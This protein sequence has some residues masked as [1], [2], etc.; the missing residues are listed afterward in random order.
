MFLDERKKRILQ[1][2][3]NDYVKFAEPIASKII[4][5]KYDLDLSSATIRNEMAELEELGLI[6]KT[7]TSSG[8]VPSDL[9]YRYYV[10][11]LMDYYDV[12]NEELTNL[13]EYLE[14]CGKMLTD[15]SKMLSGLTHYTTISM[16]KN[17]MVLYGR[18]NVFDYPEF[19]DI[20]RLKKFM[21]LMEEEERIR[22]IVDSYKNT[23][24]T[25]RIGN[26]NNFDEVKDY[27]VVTFNYKDE[28]T[29]A[30]IGPKR[31]DYSRV[32]SYI[33]YLLDN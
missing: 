20:E 11:S 3:V 5:D 25:I 31:M 10:D 28:G 21:Y 32:V 12:S 1:A 13:A 33:R 16:D 19:R 6:E 26:E 15:I 24:I 27:S 8:R 22:E 9:G 14:G 4:A 7:H 23:D 17:D 18:N 29:I 2:I 30:I